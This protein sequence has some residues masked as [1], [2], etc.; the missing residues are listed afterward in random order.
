MSHHF[1]PAEELV[2]DLTTAEDHSST[3]KALEKADQYISSPPT[4]KQKEEVK[5]VQDR[6]VI[7]RAEPSGGVSVGGVGV[8]SDQ[9]AFLQSLEEDARERGERR[10]E[11]EARGKEAKKKG[12]KAF[13]VGDYESAVQYFTEGIR[14]TPWD[15]TL[16]TNR[17]LVSA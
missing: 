10:K 9:A 3:A 16:Y 15:I 11:R 12:N 1:S 4:T 2:R 5:T 13:K 8:N 7:N 6:T 14:E 17:A